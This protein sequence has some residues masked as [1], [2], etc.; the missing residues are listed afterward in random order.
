[1]TIRRGRAAWLMGLATAVAV[2]APQTGLAQGLAQD[3]PR[4]PRAAPL[5]G[6][7]VYLMRGF[8]NVFS[9]GMDALC[10]K[11]L[12][13]GIHC[14][15]HN[16]AEWAFLADQAAAE[17]KAGRVRHIMVM[18]H[19][20][21][22]TSS[23]DMAS[24]LNEAGVPVSL[25]VTFDPISPSTVTP[26]VRHLVNLYLPASWGAPV[27][28]HPNFRGKLENLDQGRLPDIGHVNLAMSPV[29]HQ[30]AIGYVLA[31]ARSGAPA[32]VKQRPSPSANITG[33]VSTF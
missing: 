19:S 3:G 25:V 17:F 9:R 13:R 24:R 6:V 11:M 10:D 30:K 7:H 8:M 21:G 4:K 33:G 18:G 15:V 12:P 27:H 14:T 28:R 31:A 29:L 20:W 23:V 1:M 5:P 22:A 2:L 32:M 16:H 26:N